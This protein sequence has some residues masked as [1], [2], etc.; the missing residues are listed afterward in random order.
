MTSIPSKRRR[1]GE[2]REV[3]VKKVRILRKEKR[4]VGLL[5]TQSNQN[6]IKVDQNLEPGSKSP[7]EPTISNIAFSSKP[8]PELDAYSRHISFWRAFVGGVL[9]LAPYSVREPGPIFLGLQ[10]DN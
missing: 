2:T 9:H 7:K 3:K 5:I 4:I 6:L 8:A 10:G 1:S